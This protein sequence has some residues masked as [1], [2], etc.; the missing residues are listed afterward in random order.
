MRTRL[1]WSVLYL[2]VYYA[3]A[4]DPGGSNSAGRKGQCYLYW[5]YNRAFYNQSD[6]HLK[7]EHFDFTIH[8]AK[9]ED[10]PEKFDP[11]VYF[12][13]SSLTVPQFN[14]RAGYFIGPHT[15]VSLGWD[16][17]KYRLVTTQKATISGYI[18]P[19]FYPMPGYSGSFVHSDILYQPAF[20]DFHH[21]DGFNFVRASV[22]QQVPLWVPER[23]KV[24]L[25]MN[26]AASAGLML[27]WTDFTFFGQHYRNKLHL[28]GYGISASAGF[29]LEFLNWLF[30]QFSMQTGFADMRD[31]TIQDHLPSRAQQKI[32]FFE[33][34]AAIGGYIPT[35]KRR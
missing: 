3:H 32:V 33:R 19:E 9:A 10:M 26:G 29:R 30:V 14:F 22:E 28:A 25:M 8:K 17:M 24:Q 35:G 21:S 11:S 34:S 4:Q 7:G 13:P 1:L 15:S 31:I 20:M 2:T 16:H 18:D 27:P 12:N 5:G 23:G 6:V